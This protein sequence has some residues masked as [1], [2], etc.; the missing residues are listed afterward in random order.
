MIGQ[1]AWLVARVKPWFC[2]TALAA[3]GSPTQKPSMR[4]ACRCAT[5]CGGGTTTLSTSCNG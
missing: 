4:P 2:F 5:I 3:H 1:I